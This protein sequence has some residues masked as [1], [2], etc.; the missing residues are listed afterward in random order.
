MGILK[1]VSNILTLPRNRGILWIIAILSVFAV[2]ALQQLGWFRVVELRTYD[3]VLGSLPAPEADPRVRIIGIDDRAIDLVGQWPW[4][5]SILADG[6]TTLAEFQPQAVLLD[7]EISERSPWLV[8]R[9]EWERVQGEFPDLVPTATVRTVLTDRDQLLAE[10]VAAVGGVTIP[11]TIEDRDTL[12]LR[13]AL[14][15]LRAAAAG[16]GFSNLAIDRDGVSRRVE[17]V[18]RIDGEPLYQLALETLG[19]T[20]AAPGDVEF[21]P[22]GR[23]LN[24]ELTLSSGDEE[25]TLPLT[26]SGELLMRW[27]ERPFADSFPQLSWATLIEYQQAMEDLVFNLRLMEQ[28]GYVDQRSQSVIQTAD[29]ADQALRAARSRGSTA[30]FDEYRR[31]RQAFVALAGGF[32]QGEAEDRILEDLATIAGDDAPQAVVEQIETV[33]SDVRATFSATREI[34]A[35]VDRLRAFLDER[36]PGSLSLVGYTATSTIDLGVTPFDESFPNLGLHASVISMMSNDDFIDQMPWY[37]S[38]TIGT[39]WM[40]LVGIVVARRTGAASLVLAAV[41]MLFPPVAVVVV[42]NALRVYLP[43]VSLVLPTVVVTLAVLTYDYLNALRDRQVVRSTFEHYLAPEVISELVDHP[44]RLGVGGTEESLTAMFSDIARFSRVSEILGTAEVVSLLNEYLTEMS[45]VILD[46]R[47]T[48]DKYEGDAI[49]AFF[50]APVRTAIHAEQACRAAIQ[51]KK[52]EGLLNDRL[53]RSGAAPQPLVTRIGV[54]SGSMIV[55]NLGTTRRLNYTVMGPAV[56][57]AS[58]LEGVNKQYGTAICIG[59]G[60]RDLLPEG[61]LLRRM[62]RVRVK[63]TDQPVRLYEL[64]GYRE[65]SSAPLRE[66]LDLFDRGL[67]DFEARRWQA[68]AQRFETVQRIYP[69]D[70]PAKLFLSRCQAFLKEEPRDTW[71][72]VITLTRK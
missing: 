47:G 42:M 72:G 71:D 55:G 12:R 29:A 23:V 48:I 7:V 67:V 31:L 13:R 65:E 35:E 40:I 25:R 2:P 14:P 56:N 37:W 27:P 59:E 58:R 28:A 46:H 50:G 34:Y 62:D 6:L 3:S 60:T 69:D 64:L 1:H 24:R 21:G 20:L 18:R 26:A 57:L 32:L 19:Y 52:V 33:R 70:G 9:R 5:R 45:D 39:V 17:V 4:S 15:A 63:G 10:S 11:A 43:A 41:G 30:L 66:A 8:Q 51:M 44:D 54:N 53:V 68:A 61:F 16:E 22:D 36:V 49:M 38:W